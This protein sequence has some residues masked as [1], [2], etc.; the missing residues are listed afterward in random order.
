MGRLPAQPPTH[1]LKLLLFHNFM[2]FDVLY[3]RSTRFT[4]ANHLA[5]LSPIVDS[6][7]CPRLDLVSEKASLLV[8]PPA[9]MMLFLLSL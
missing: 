4:V 2:R 5:K 3:T 7:D 8:V 9:I 6:I 1:N